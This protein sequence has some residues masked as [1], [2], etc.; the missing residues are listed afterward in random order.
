MKRIFALVMCLSNSVVGFSQDKAASGSPI[1]EIPPGPTMEETTKWI[2]REI[3]TIGTYS[4]VKVK[5]D[6]RANPYTTEYRI[7][8][9]DFSN[10]RLS[11]RRTAETFV[12]SGHLYMESY[13]ETATMKDVDVS[14]IR[15]LVVPVPAGSTES[16]PNYLV[17]LRAAPDRGQ[18][19]TSQRKFEDKKDPEKPSL[20]V[21]LR[22]GDKEGANQAAY[23]LYRAAVLCGA[24]NN[25]FGAIA[26]STS[27]ELAKASGRF[28]REDKP[29]DS[30]ELNS[31]G[32]LLLKQSG[33][34]YPGKFYVQGD[35]ITAGTLNAPVSQLRI[36]GNSMEESD[37][38]VW[39]KQDEPQTPTG[40]ALPT[41]ASARPA[42]DSKS[43][44][45]NDSII[46]VV[47]NG[48]S[49]PVV[50]TMIRQAPAKD[51]DL[52]PTG[53]IALK[54]AGVSDTVI[55]VMQEKNS[56]EPKPST[57]ETKP[58]PKYDSTLVQQSKPSSDNGCSGIE[59]LGLYK[60]EVMSGAIGGGLVEWLAK[61]RNN[62]TVTRIVVFGWRDMYG[63][64]Q[65]AQV[66][67]RGGDIATPRLDMT[68][69]RVIP[70]VA[71]LR[72]LS[73]Q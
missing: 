41:S 29:G 15:V 60:N 16:K 21:Q 6:D 33:K 40:T 4:I 35:T 66:Q 13:A 62:T 5:N 31:N 34:E 55:A 51:F 27:D 24:P 46:L 58:P 9:A 36:R 63:Q 2:K 71:D 19:F 10:C 47:K 70:P 7:E 45:T 72:L 50:S 25:P 11:L 48:L 12:K 56:P 65:T 1:S 30:L 43:K 42:D 23:M 28:N 44:M 38:T 14:K 20:S 26:D 32:T 61:I 53:L 54:K 52:T 22:F 49:D 69:A 67:I 59:S 3:P 8:K 73:C 68:Q 57:N 37:G 18:P 17:Y 39:E 64:Q